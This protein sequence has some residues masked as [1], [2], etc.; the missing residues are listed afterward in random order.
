M[1]DILNTF[2]VGG[3]LGIGLVVGITQIIKLQWGLEG[4]AAVILAAVVSVIVAGLGAAVE[5][6]PQL[7]RPI[8]FLVVAVVLWISSAGAY[9]VVNTVAK[10]FRKDAAKAQDNAP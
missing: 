2:V 1:D 3:A 4:R 9:S 6:L 10:G 7:S 5:F 8:Y